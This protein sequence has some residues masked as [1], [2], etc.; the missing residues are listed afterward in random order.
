[1]GLGRMVKQTFLP[2]PGHSHSGAVVT[3]NRQTLLGPHQSLVRDS[4]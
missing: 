1:M 3:P 2:L 4:Y